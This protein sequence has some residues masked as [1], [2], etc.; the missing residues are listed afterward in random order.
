[1]RGVAVDEGTALLVDATFGVGLVVTRQRR[2]LLDLPGYVFFGR[3]LQG[4]TL[5]FPMGRLSTSDPVEIQRVGAYQL[6][7]LNT[8]EPV[9]RV[10]FDR[11]T[12][13][14]IDGQ[15]R[16]RGLLLSGDLYYPLSSRDPRLLLKHLAYGQ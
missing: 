13:Q 8:W 6:F 11:F 10:P 3:A 16:S 12:V 2:P 7:D 15:S 5:G 9:S 1:M 14:I 4:T